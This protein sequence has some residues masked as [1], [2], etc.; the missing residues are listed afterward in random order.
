M[1]IKVVLQDVL[2]FDFF[3]VLKQFDSYFVFLF[4]LGSWFQV[5]YYIENCPKVY[6]TS[7]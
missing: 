1:M 5:A 4:Y 7:V 6:K 3:F 2:H